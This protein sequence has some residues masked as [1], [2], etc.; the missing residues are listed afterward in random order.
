MCHIL[1]DAENEAVQDFY[2]EG[3]DA[4]N[5]LTHCKE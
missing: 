3:D 2:R 5:M 4:F 1:S